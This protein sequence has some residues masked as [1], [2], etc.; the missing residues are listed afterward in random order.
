VIP[1]S[2]LRPL[3]ASRLVVAACLLPLVLSLAGCGGSRLLGG[4]SAPQDG[5][6]APG[7]PLVMEP[8]PSA[9][10]QTVPIEPGAAPT[11]AGAA[12]R[13]A[14]LLP[15][16]GPSAGLGRAM[17]D[18]AQMAVFDIGD[19]Q[20]ELLP[21][22]TKGTPEGAATAA[23]AAL[24]DGAQ[25]LLGPLLAAEVEA[26]KP[27]AK[28]AGISMVAFSTA[29]QLAGDG[30]FLMSFL[31]KQQ[32]ERVTAFAKEKGATRYA[33]L[34]PSTPYGNLVVDA[35]QQA[36]QANGGSVG[37]VEYYDPA[38]VDNTAAVRRI[39][40]AGELDALLLPEGGAKLKAL[41]PLLPYFDI[42]TERVHLLGTGLWDEPG[43]GVEPALI[44]G[45]FAAPP[46]EARADFEKRFQELY[47][48][49]P[50]RLATLGYDGAALGA[51]LARGG[52]FS[53]AAVMNPSGFAGV[54][55]I[56]RFTPDGLVQRGLAVLEVQKSGT[57]VVSPAPETFQ[58]LGF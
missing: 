56:F 4:S 58:Q 29:T 12:H 42:D 7:E 16:S 20:V 57:T 8:A 31:P 30:T 11:P 28:Q 19:E 55:G 35:F 43:L 49:R 47:K 34:A 27:I 14:I 50:P 21:R 5:R 46:P 53:P 45:W 2:S 25:L 13:V 37:R 17:L 48:R 6:S 1:F 51:L 15:L 24:G 33:A 39:A 52:D 40:G 3:R 32:V 54:D 9:P 41:A 23:R 22:D 10:V 38:A 26:A 18:A 36:V 44:G